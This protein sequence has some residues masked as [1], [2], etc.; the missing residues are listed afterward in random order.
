M[1]IAFLGTSVTKGTDH[2][3]VAAADTFAYKIGVDNGY[4]VANII[5]A[6][7]SS[8]TAAGMLARL[9][10]DV[11]SYGPDVCVVEVGVN[12]WAMSVSVSSFR[13]D[14]S[15]ILSELVSASI[16]PVGM[17]KMQRGSTGDFASYQPYL[18]ALEDEC[19]AQGA[20]LVDLF[21]EECASYLYL[22]ASAFSANYVDNVHLTVAGHQFVADLA[23]RDKYAGV[24]T[25]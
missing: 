16:K 15:D 9:T 21:R 2:G 19:A 14:V 7:V 1:K 20:E 18:H 13:S 4:A 24:F 8:D 11:I 22:S 6:G 12:D 25:I 5:N 10:S 3:G 23:A 17:T